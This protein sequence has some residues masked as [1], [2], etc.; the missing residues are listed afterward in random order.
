MRYEAGQAPPVWRVGDVIDGRYEVGHV[1]DSGGMGLVY[2]VRQ[3]EW[4][5]DLAVKSPRPELIRDE[6]DRRR[7]VAEAEAWVALGLHPNV[8]ACEYVRTLG[9][10]PR[11]F[12]EYVHGGSLHDLIAGRALYR[13]DPERVLARVLDLAIQTAWGLEHSH[14]KGLVHQDVKPH[15]VLVDRDGT[16]KVTDFG[17]A[18][19]GTAGPGT[20]LAAAGSGASVLVTSG[21]LTR[22]Y[23][24]PEQLAGERLGRR[25]DVFSFAVSVL[26]MFTGGVSWMFGPAAAE[27]LELWREEG[28][29]EPGLPALPRVVA[30]L[31]GRCLRED[32]A[33]RPAS[34]AEVADELTGIYAALTGVAYPRTRPVA[35]DLRADEH[36]NRALSLLDLGRPADAEAELTAA[37]RADPGHL[38]AAYNAGLI[39]WRRGEISDEDLVAA[40]ERAGSGERAGAAGPLLAQVHLERGDRT[41]AL[42][43]LDRAGPDDPEAAALLDLL[44]SGR[45]A[46]ANCVSVRRPP[47]DRRPSPSA[48]GGPSVDDVVLVPGANL[49][50]AGDEDGLVRVWDLDTGAVRPNLDRLDGD[51][52]TIAVG[53]G[54]YAVSRGPR[55]ARFWDLGTGR[56]LRVFTP[57]DD[58]PDPGDPNFRW[59]GDV[60]RRRGQ[61]VVSVHIDAAGALPLAV[62]GAGRIWDLR[63]GRLRMSLH[64]RRDSAYVVLNATARRMLSGGAGDG[65]RLWDLDSGECLRVLPGEFSPLISGAISDDG[66]LALI[67]TLSD[68][69]GVWDL[70]TG[71]RVRLLPR[72]SL[73]GRTAP[74]TSGARRVLTGHEGAVRLWDLDW[75]LAALSPRTG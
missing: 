18:R 4:G 73:R 34:M 58:D 2:R 39:R 3:L 6:A 35:S 37:L 74:F 7:F 40:I 53:G 27:A 11:V 63:T 10:I 45:I 62:D 25:T 50:V 17:L 20:T 64:P 46:D 48:A 21:G 67:R 33:A 51:L 9:G 22:A 32:P 75:D 43:L 26:E 1:H 41:S 8:C 5:T 72:A 24:S 19:A 66:R 61:D 36:N 30:R 13:G 65:C 52:R 14:A 49:V 12:A 56:C 23:A 71:T 68:Q 28:P 15:N 44:G 54:R 69:V 47:W 38:E 59:R 57:P 29:D 70:G 55:A 42:A 31:L 60:R 16:A